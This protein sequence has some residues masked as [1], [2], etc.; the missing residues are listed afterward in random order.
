MKTPELRDI[1]PTR[2]QATIACNH[3][4]LLSSNGSYGGSCG[5]CPRPT[6]TWTI[7]CQAAIPELP[8]LPD[9]GF[10]ADFGAELLPP[11]FA[12]DIGSLDLGA[13]EF[14]DLDLGMF[15]QPYGD[16]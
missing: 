15:M 12:S 5:A 4:R 2:L 11:S 10:H 14:E 13:A 9:G 1:Q 7:L 8:E 16:A 3:V 6:L